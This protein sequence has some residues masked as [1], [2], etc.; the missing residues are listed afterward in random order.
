[1]TRTSVLA[2]MLLLSACVAGGYRDGDIGIDYYEPYYG[3][4]VGIY[5]AWGTDYRVGPYRRG[6]WDGAHGETRPHGYRQPPAGRTPPTIPSSPRT[7]GG[8]RPDQ[9]HQ[10]QR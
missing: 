2:V 8:G 5:G 6:D 1:M 10:R 3:P 7:H 9:T 4:S